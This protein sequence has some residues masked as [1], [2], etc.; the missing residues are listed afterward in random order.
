MIVG[1]LV[2]YLCW[3]VKNALLC[4]ERK[5]IECV[6]LCASFAYATIR[7]TINAALAKH[8]RLGVHILHGEQAARL[9]SNALSHVALF[10]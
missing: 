6:L 1:R 5:G 3:D 2:E 10:V 4:C 8:A 7:R 9:D